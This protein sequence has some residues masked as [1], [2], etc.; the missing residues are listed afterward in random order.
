MIYSTM[1]F[2]NNSILDHALDNPVWN[3]MISSSSNLAL[4]A[5]QIKFFPEDLSPFVG[6]EN[7]NEE[8]LQQLFEMISNERIVAI[9]TARSLNIPVDVNIIR[10]AKLLQMTRENAA[11]P[12]V[13][14]EGIEPLDK[15]HVPQMLA[16]TRLTNPG[17]FLERT[18]EFGNYTGIFNEG[19][20]AAMAGRRL[21][22]DQYVEVS[23]VC[24]H[25]DHAGK[26]YGS[27]LILNQV[28]Q[29]MNEGNIPFLHVAEDNHTAI[30]LYQRLGFRTRQT[31]NLY[32]MQKAG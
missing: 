14:L 28:C 22:V 26:G 27:R 2:K 25:P 8:S 20:L 7:V 29:I 15:K 23:A 21:H 19:E 30:Q 4:G 17:P 16:L 10:Q 5:G 1:R 3:A 18:I 31:M 11:L 24:T 6:L 13:N 32:V 12:S 9:V